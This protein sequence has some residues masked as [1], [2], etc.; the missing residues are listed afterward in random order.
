MRHS[1][2]VSPIKITSSLDLEL[3]RQTSIQPYRLQRWNFIEILV[4][5]N[6][7]IILSSFWF[8]PF[9]ARLSCWKLQRI[10]ISFPK[11]SEYNNSKLRRY[12][13]ALIILDLCQ[14]LNFSANHPEG[15]AA[16]KCS[17]EGTHMWF[18]SWLWKILLTDSDPN[19]S[20]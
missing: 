8:Y 20:Y 2:K 17:L 3:I 14:L 18:S 1:A 4:E 5:F 10:I 13:I 9:N 15:L 7:Y 6:L 12:S 11:Y 19:N 16:Y